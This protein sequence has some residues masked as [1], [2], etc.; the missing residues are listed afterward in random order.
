MSAT[1]LWTLAAAACFASVRGSKGEPDVTI[2]VESDDQP[3]AEVLAAAEITATAMFARIGVRAAWAPEGKRGRPAIGVVLHLHITDRPE[4]G[5]EVLGYAYP[6]AGDTQSVTI[7]WRR[8]RAQCQDYPMQAPALL[9]HVM[10]HEVAHVL[11]GISR[12]SHDGVM[13]AQWSPEDLRNMRW[14]PLPFTDA[15]ARFI[16][17]GLARLRRF[18]LAQAGTHHE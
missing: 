2:R 8:V 10:V 1:V 15:D 16:Q 3:G 17:S 18:E 14:Q 7:V 4:E 11:Q 12:H 6:Y 13:K 9:A 5:K